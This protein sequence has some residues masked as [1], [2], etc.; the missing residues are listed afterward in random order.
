MFGGSDQEE[1]VV[2][3]ICAR[4][5]GKVWGIRFSASFKSAVKKLNISQLL[6]HAGK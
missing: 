2:L 5:C 1:V 3:C 4:E 6:F